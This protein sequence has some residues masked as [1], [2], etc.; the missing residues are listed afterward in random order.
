MQ[1]EE[2]GAELC[3]CVLKRRKRIMK[4]R[5]KETK[6]LQVSVVSIFFFDYWI[7]IG[8][9]ESSDCGVRCLV[10]PVCSYYGIRTFAV[11]RGYFLEGDGDRDSSGG[12]SKVR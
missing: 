11:I 6:E 2:R 10:A 9:S 12:C 1:R 7:T 3:S 5:K 8:W 4:G